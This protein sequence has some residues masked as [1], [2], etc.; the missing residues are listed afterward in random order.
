M[1]L[2]AEGGYAKKKQEAKQ[3]CIYR[4]IAAMLA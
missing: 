4:R 3:P 1:Q 2:C